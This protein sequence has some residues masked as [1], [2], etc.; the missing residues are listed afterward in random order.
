VLIKALKPVQDR[1]TD[2]PVVGVNTVRNVAAAGLRG[3]AI[4]AGNALVINEAAVIE[5]ADAARVFVLGFA[6]T[7]YSD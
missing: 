2:L 3:I 5:A 6:A 7:A 1:K 4:E